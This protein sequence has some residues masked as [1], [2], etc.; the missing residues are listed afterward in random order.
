MSLTRKICSQSG[1]PHP[2]LFPLSELSF[3]VETP[4]GTN[5][6][7]KLAKLP[8]QRAGTNSSATPSAATLPLA[9]WQQYGS[10]GGDAQLEK[11]LREL[12]VTLHQPKYEDWGV[13]CCVGAGDGIYKSLR[14]LCEPGDKVI[15]E[16]YTYPATLETISAIGL[17]KVP[18]AMDAEG[19]RADSLREALEN[20]S[21]GKKPVCMCRS[22]EVRM[23]SLLTGRHCTQWTEPHG[24]HSIRRE[25]S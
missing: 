12:T 3:E 19:M 20:W 9:S 6:A 4:A 14:L 17:A 13:T 16:A 23:E 10:A 7:Y 1:Y 8:S 21:D 25:V 5:A 24:L 18:I 22:S 15:V 11:W 2:S